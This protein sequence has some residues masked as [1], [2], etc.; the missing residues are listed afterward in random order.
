MDYEV[1][2]VAD[3]DAIPLGTGSHIAL[4]RRRLGIES[5]GINAY[6]ASAAGDPLVVRH[7]ELGGRPPRRHE[8]IYYVAAGEAAFELDGKTLTALAGTF[9]YLSDPA[10]ERAAVAAAD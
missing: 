10:V 6:V 3:V 9:V 8:E 1:I 2:T 4:L 5:F 7:S